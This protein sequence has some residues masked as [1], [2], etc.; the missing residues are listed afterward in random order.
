HRLEIIDHRGKLE[1]VW[2]QSMTWVSADGKPFRCN[3]LSFYELKART[4]MHGEF[5]DN[6]WTLKAVRHLNF[7]GPCGQLA[8]VGIECHLSLSRDSELIANCDHNKLVLE[9]SKE[10]PL[11]LA[12]A[13]GDPSEVTGVWT[14]HMRSTDK[15]RDVKIENET[16]QLVQKQKHV[17]GFYDRTVTIRSADNRRFSCNNGMEYT[18]TTRFQIEGKMEGRVLHIRE[19]SYK[20]QPGP[21]ET[22]ERVLDE[23]KGILSP[24]GL[25]IRLEWGKGAQLL[26]RRY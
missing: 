21:C 10:R 17:R 9:K 11:P 8:P 2:I 1:A 7:A 12:V 13:L 22:G 20:A 24:N 18:N 14:W 25:T 26:Y 3:G 19:V 4:L 6:G 23:Y 5:V 16:W 15:E